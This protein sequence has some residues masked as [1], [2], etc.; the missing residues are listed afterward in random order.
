MG[1]R[2]L[3]GF[4]D[5]DLGSVMTDAFAVDGS[6]ETYVRDWR[7]LADPAVVEQQPVSLADARAQFEAAIEIGDMIIPPYESDSW[8]ASRPLLEWVLAKLPTGGSDFDDRQPTQDECDDLIEGFLRSPQ[9]RQRQS[10][11]DA[12]R[13]SIRS[14]GSEGRTAIRCCGAPRLSASSSAISCRTRW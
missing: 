14:S 8:P 10:D 13:S 6:L 12:P 3:V 1:I 7:R 11:D 2:S 9:G 4:V 5:C